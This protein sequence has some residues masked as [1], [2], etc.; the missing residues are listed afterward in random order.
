MSFLCALIYVQVSSFLKT[1]LHEMSFVA[2]L[3][4]LSVVALVNSGMHHIRIF[5]M[6]NRLQMTTVCRAARDFARYVLVIIYAASRLFTVT[7]ERRAKH[8]ERLQQD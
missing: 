8:A 7:L 4:L 1:L 5:M 2:A 3:V 6:P